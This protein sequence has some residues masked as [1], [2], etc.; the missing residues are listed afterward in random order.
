M[1][2]LCCR[3]ILNEYTNKL[4]EIVE[5]LLK[6]MARSLKLKEDSFLD[7]Y[8]ERAIM[9][10][11]FNFYPPCPRPDLVLGL[12]PHSDGSA[13]TILLQDREVEGLQFMKDDQWVRVPNNIPHALLVNVGDQVEVTNTTILV[14]T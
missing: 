1:S 4:R 3:E 2:I 5:L 12:K 13:V 9:T 14:H 6:A 8:G 10:G 11:R 7:Q